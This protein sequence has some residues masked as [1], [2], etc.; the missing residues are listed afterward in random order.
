[1]SDRRFIPP[2]TGQD[3]T[4]RDTHVDQAMPMD[5]DDKDQP[6]DIV[7]IEMEPV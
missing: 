2:D 4:E 3:H 1:M 7:E 6:T 5:L